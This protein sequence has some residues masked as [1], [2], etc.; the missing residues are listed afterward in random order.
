MN[1]KIE[2]IGQGKPNIAIIGCVHGD[3]IIGKKVINQL[4]KIKLKKGTLTFI[5]AHPKAVAKKKRFFQKDLNRSFPGRKNGMTEEKIAY[6]LNKILKKFDLVIDVHATNSDLKSLI[7]IT[8]YNKQIKNLLK[9]TPIKRV[10]YAPKKVFGAKELITY[11]KL[12]VSLEY[13]PN[14]SGRN[15]KRALNHV[16]IILKNLGVLKGKKTL[17]KEKDLYKISGIYRV[18]N[19]FQQNNKLKD[20]QLIKKGQLI[21]KINKK[22]IYSDKNFHPLFLGKGRYQ[23]TLALMAKKEKIKL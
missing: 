2:T 11:S 21:G 4:K 8:K 12:G 3:E 7:A 13:G 1:Y 5:I 9:I 17:Y 6:E 22:A 15:Y 20:Y 23:E 10:A 14:K 16:K 18:P 19:N